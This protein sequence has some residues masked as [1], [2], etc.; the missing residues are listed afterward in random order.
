LE[1]QLDGN[2]TEK[3]RRA[4]EERVILSDLSGNGHADSSAHQSYMAGEL[5]HFEVRRPACGS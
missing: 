1:G 3:A 4:G 2:E 5:D